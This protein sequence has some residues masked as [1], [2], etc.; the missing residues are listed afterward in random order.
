MAGRRCNYRRPDPN[1][2]G[3]EMEHEYGDTV[4][5]LAEYV[6][7]MAQ[8]VAEDQIEDLFRQFPEVQQHLDYV[9]AGGESG[10]SLTTTHNLT[11]VTSSRRRRHRS[12][13]SSACTVL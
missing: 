13:K 8:E 6:K 2:L 9:L 3:F 12:S 11:M 10:R 7:D 4:E 5:G 1:V